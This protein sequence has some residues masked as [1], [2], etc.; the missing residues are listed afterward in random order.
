MVRSMPLVLKLG[1]LTLLSLIKYPYMLD[2]PSLEAM[3]AVVREGSFERAAQALHVTPSAISQRVKL[4]EE[5]LGRVLV[6]RGQPCVATEAGRQLCRHVEQVGLLEHGLR[7]A[8]PGLLPEPDAG[9]RATLRV[10]VNADS[11]GG[12]FME[13]ARVFTEGGTELLDISLDDQDHTAQWLRSGEVLAAIT[14][15]AK[16][17]QGCN[18]VA[19]GHI[20]YVAVASPAFFQRYFP[21]GVDRHSLARAP[22]LVFNQK[23]LLQKQWLDQH[24]GAGLKPPRHWFPATQAFIDAGLAGIGWGMHPAALIAPHLASGALLALRPDTP[25]DVA[26]HWQ[27]VRVALPALQRL[28]QVV[29]AT[30]RAQLAR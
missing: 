20:P 17:V 27:H 30:A 15:I 5:R 26:L 7:Q 12:W 6:L 14:A 24:F 3:A 28:T 2:Y 1:Q 11:L 22:V 18:S 8:L 9:E 10:A 4:L 29:C 19:L 21:Q 23:D 25:L 13:A 16:P